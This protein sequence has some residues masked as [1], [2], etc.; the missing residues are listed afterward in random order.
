VTARHAATAGW[1]AVCFIV[2]PRFIGPQL[3]GRAEGR[4]P[5]EEGTAR[6][7]S[8]ALRAEITCPACL[9]IL[10][11]I[12]ELGLRVKREPLWL[13]HA[14]TKKGKVAL[15]AFAKRSSIR[16]RKWIRPPQRGELFN[17]RSLAHHAPALRAALKLDRP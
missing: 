6:I 14:K 16:G 15:Y 11:T 10:D 3:E 1:G 2:R 12:E 5:D 7:Y 8:T 13:I 4:H 17:G 9:V